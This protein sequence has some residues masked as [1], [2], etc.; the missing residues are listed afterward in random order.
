LLLLEDLV[1]EFLVDRH[2]CLSFHFVVL[3]SQVR[4]VVGVVCLATLKMP[5]SRAVSGA[6]NSNA[7]RAGRV[8]VWGGT[9]PMARSLV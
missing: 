6:D 8:L 9:V 4:G 3:I 5:M 1:V 2:E 7:P